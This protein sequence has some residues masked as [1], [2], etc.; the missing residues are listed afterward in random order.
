MLP[1]FTTILRL[2]DLHFCEVT[3]KFLK[4]VKEARAAF[5]K[6]TND[7][8][9][10]SFIV[11]EKRDK[12]RQSRSQPQ[13]LHQGG[14]EKIPAAAAAGA[15]TAA[16][17][18]KADKDDEHVSSSNGR[19]KRI[20]SRDRRSPL[21]R[22]L[23][24][25]VQAEVSSTDVRVMSRAEVKADAY[26]KLSSILDAPKNVKVALRAL[27]CFSLLIFIIAVE[28]ISS[29]ECSSSRGDPLW[30]DKCK[31]PA[32]P[33]FHRIMGDVRKEDGICPCTVLVI[34]DADNATGWSGMRD[35]VYLR[36]AFFRNTTVPAL[37]PLPKSIK[38]LKIEQGGVADISALRGLDNLGQ[39]QLS[40]NP[41]LGDVSSLQNLTS[42]YVGVGRV[43]LF[44]LHL[45]LHLIVH[46][47]V[48]AYCL[49]HFPRPLPCLFPFAQ[50][51]KHHNDWHAAA[52][53]SRCAAWHTYALRVSHPHVVTFNNVGCFLIRIV[54]CYRAAGCHAPPAPPPLV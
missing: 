9:A 48:L 29:A 22:A 19:I 42:M 17:T 53:Y 54:Y 39:L 27:L 16:A 50:Q 4:N 31:R 44:R 46:V 21:T 8:R 43:V 38:W 37:P 12:Q 7:A 5:L 23:S 15:D 14:E 41:L 24:S 33:A 3:L 36:T 26:D 6:Q 49:S 34:N 25:S 40:G 2:K 35:S 30:A 11:A 45:R 20:K 52:R 28:G 32:R 10:A 1:L 18:G 47:C 13:Q 51:L